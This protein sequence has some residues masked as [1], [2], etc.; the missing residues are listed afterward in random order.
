[1]LVI[2]G[3]TWSCSASRDENLPSQCLSKDDCEDGEECTVGQCVV[4]RSASVSA[5]GD[6]EGAPP[7][8]KVEQETVG[9]EVCKPGAEGGLTCVL[10]PGGKVRWIAPEVDGY[11]FVGWTG[12]DER[13]ASDERVLELTKLER[14]TSCVA[15]Y[16]RRLR[17]SGRVDGQ[18]EDDDSLA[19]TASSDA[20]L[21]SCEASS[22]EVDRGDSVTLLAPER[23]GFRLTGFEGS[24]CH[25]RKGSRVVVT[26]KD[27][28]VTCTAVY[29]E[30]LTVRGQIQGLAPNDQAAVEASS[31]H[32]TAV[33]EA[34]LCGVDPGATVTLTAPAVEGYRF[35]GWTGD[36][37]CTSGA[38]TAEIS[39]VRQNI[40]CIADYVPRFTVT[41]KSE[42]AEA[43][44]SASSSNLFSV[45][46]GPRC[47]VDQGESVTLIAGT[48]SG[49]RLDTWSGEGCAQADGD[50]A[51]AADVSEDRTCVA[52]FIRGVAVSGTVVNATGSVEASS[53]SAGADCARGRCTIDVGGAVTLTAPL[54]EGRTFMGWSGDPGC[55][56]VNRVLV[57]SDV[58]DSKACR[59]TFTPRHL[60]NGRALPAAGGSIVA[61]STGRNAS[62]QAARCE[63][64]QGSAVVLTASAA[65]SF[66]FTGWSGGGPCSGN[67][68]RLEL[69]D[70]QNALSCN[71]NFVARVQVSS[72]V[73]PAASGT[74]NAS[75]LS[76]GATCQGGACTVDSGSSVMLSAVAS[77]GFRFTRWS[78]CETS[79]INPLIVQA[80]GDQRCT[81]NFER[82]SYVVAATAGAGG[83]VS[84]RV[85]DS[86]CANAR[87]TVEHG[88]SATFTATPTS[89]Y[90][91][92]GWSDCMTSAQPSL[93]LSNVTGA[94]TCR[95]AFTRIRLTVSAN[96]VG[97]G[98]VAATTGGSDCLL[99][100]CSVDYGA[101]V[102]VT[103][104]VPAGVEF[105]GWSGCSTSRELNVT[106][107]NVT[108]S[109]VCTAN[110]RGLSYPV[111]GQAAA[112]GGG[113]VTARTTTGS[114]S[115]SRCTVTHGGSAT[116]TATPSA[117][118]GFASWSGGPACTGGAELVLSNV[119]AEI[120]CTASFT[121]LGPFTVT[122]TSDGGQPA[123][124]SS[125]GASC[126]ASGC[127]VPYGGSATVSVTITP[128]TTLQRLI[129]WSGC[130]VTNPRF[131][132]MPQ[133][134]AYRYTGDVVNVT[135]NLNCVANLGPAAIMM[136]Y[137]EEPTRGRVE[138]TLS[139]RGDC[140]SNQPVA[141]GTY[142]VIPPGTVPTTR[143]IPNSG[144]MFS[145]MECGNEPDH[146]TNPHVSEPV[147]ANRLMFCFVHFDPPPLL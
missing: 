111:T 59:A 79:A 36:P 80:A 91:F 29:V 102:T 76:T 46:E 68:A 7:G 38:T 15:R 78:D 10:T 13:C 99:D 77:A 86:S 50:S 45:C 52:K 65:G 62:C 127:S 83:S 22:C 55:A 21:A 101:S 81:A 43:V 104:S 134:S 40:V 58:S 114:C 26:T 33:C 73:A 147:P 128:S 16:V 135:S 11:R 90:S 89:G 126:P 125:G 120:A 20:E 137:P 49:Y 41:A 71:A 66:R 24:G 117:G 84:G 31:S 132:V 106:I 18:A 32:E 9:D 28:D 85:D 129:G 57:L 60:V 105:T 141:G 39:D 97:G 69:R 25:D 108:M 123:T 19:L 92:S 121:R 30:S 140:A 2:V 103:A 8:T 96:A 113:T 27:E 63:V 23:D 93:T 131:E 98:S 17:V 5:S 124:A 112:A 75:S 110:F 144:Y 64:D 74:V 136:S 95:A 122:A 130:Q 142:C 4:T 14:D 42:G 1:V 145:Q 44:L 116:L 133:G 34:Q 47:E 138:L 82:L 109:Q 53:S 37:S 72:S 100:T 118:F 70:I 146:T 35:R 61:S 6:V 3:L 94:R 12:E 139:T 48:V 56:G 119:R 115:G 54:L 88:G 87:C 107:A 67:N 143:A 51:L